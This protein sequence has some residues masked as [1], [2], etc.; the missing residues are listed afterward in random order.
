MPRSANAFSRLGPMPLRRS[1][2][3]FE[4]SRSVRAAR[5]PAALLD[6]DVVG[7]ERLAAMMDLRGDVRTMLGEPR[8]D[9]GS[10]GRR[11]VG[12]GDQRHQLVFVGDE[13]VEKLGRRARE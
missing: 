10:V 6:A 2:G 9:H 4:K 8:L 3:S 5:S 1:T 12:A 13:G 7:V 11:C